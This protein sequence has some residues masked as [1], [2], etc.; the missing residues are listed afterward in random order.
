MGKRRNRTLSQSHSPSPVP[1]TTATGVSA[2]PFP[3]PP[4]EFVGIASQ[5]K[6]TE[7]KTEGENNNCVVQCVCRSPVSAGIQI[8]PCRHFLHYA[9]AQNFVHVSSRECPIC[10]CPISSMI[11]ASVP[12]VNP[13]QWLNHPSSEILSTC[14]CGPACQATLCSCSRALRM[15]RPE[16]HCLECCNPFNE[17]VR[18]VLLVLSNLTV[19]VEHVRN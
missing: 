3:L 16:C 13:L 12:L 6:E 9:C 1:T 7:Q 18:L 5:G 19:V 14:G 17:L 2:K 8:L 4:P 10:G 11:Q 15:C